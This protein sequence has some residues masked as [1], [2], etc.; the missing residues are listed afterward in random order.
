MKPSFTKFTLALGI[1]LI[2]TVLTATANASCGD[3]KAGTTLHRQS[4]DGFGS[5]PPGSL[6]LTSDDADN[7]VGMWHVTFTA[8]GNDGGPPDNTPIDNSIVTWHSDGTEIMN[9]GRPAQDGQF[10]MGVWKKTG[11]LKYKVNHF[12]WAGND[13]T[14]APSG[15]GNP[16]GPTHIVEEVTLSPDGKHYTGTF[17]LDAYD[18]SGNVIAHIIGVIRATRITMDT[19]VTDLL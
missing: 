17:T 10:C 6:L 2:A 3:S 19:T 16:A 14:N 15:V 5:F 18:T 9:S 13:T 7:I 12:A 4:W 1:A 8:E 11:S